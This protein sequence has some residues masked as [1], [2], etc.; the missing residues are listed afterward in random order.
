MVAST[1]GISTPYTN[2]YRSQEPPVLAF[3]PTFE[4]QTSDGLSFLPGLT[5][6][7]P[8]GLVPKMAMLMPCPDRLTLLTLSYMLNQNPLFLTTISWP[9]LS[10]SLHVF[11][12]GKTF[13]SSLLLQASK[14]GMTPNSLDIL[15]YNIPVLSCG[16]TTYGPF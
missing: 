12:P 9:Q 2:L 8:F 15:V 5:L 11:P 6:A 13:C 4:S 14:M 7:L 3:C 1:G 16:I 10:F